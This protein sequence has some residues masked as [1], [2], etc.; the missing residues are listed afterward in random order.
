MCIRDRYNTAGFCF[1]LNPGLIITI[2]LTPAT[3]AGIAFINTLDGYEAVE[4][5]T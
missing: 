4:P 3:I 5:G 1:P 2:L